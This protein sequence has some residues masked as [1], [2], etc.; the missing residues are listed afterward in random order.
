[1]SKKINISIFKN[2]NAYLPECQAYLDFFHSKGFKCVMDDFDSETNVIIIFPSFNTFFS[3]LPKSKKLFVI[4]DYPSLS[5]PPFSFFKNLIKSFIFPKPQL[6]VFLNEKVKEGFKFSDNVPFIFRDMGV[7]SNFFTFPKYS[8]KYDVVYCGYQHKGLD[9][10]CEKLALLGFSLLLIGKYDKRFEHKFQNLKNVHFLGFVPNID[11]PNYYAECTYGLNFTPDVYPFN[12]Q[13]STKTIEYCAL[14]LKII[15]NKYFWIKNF[16]KQNNASFFWLEDMNSKAQ[17]ED[18]IFKTP[19]VKNMHWNR[20]LSD[21]RLSI[22][23][24]KN[25]QI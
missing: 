15:S 23:I 10:V 4:H 17:V 5:V 16:E 22:I 2:N 20:I 13:T 1:M 25:F 8:H 19:S 7:P 21:S 12:I 3:K 6:R 9:K 11:L 18:F 14:G 24:E